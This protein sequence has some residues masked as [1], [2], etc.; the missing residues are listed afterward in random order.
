M[1]NASPP[2]ALH[3]GAAGDARLHELMAELEL[4]T[5]SLQG[6]ARAFWARRLGTCAAALAGQ[7]AEEAVMPVAQLEF[8]AVAAGADVEEGEVGA[9]EGEQDEAGAVEGEH[10]EAWYDDDGLWPG[11]QFRT[12]F[13][14]YHV[15]PTD[16]H[17]GH[18]ANGEHV[19]AQRDAR[20][21][22]G[23][24]QDSI[25]LGEHGTDIYCDHCDVGCAPNTCMAVV[26]LQALGVADTI[27]RHQRLVAKTESMGTPD[28][29]ARA[30]ARFECYKAVIAWQFSDPLGAGQRRRLPE[31]V[32]CKVRCLFRNP[33]C[34]PAACD[35][36][37]ECERR[38]HYTG[39]RTAE[40]SRTLREAES[41]V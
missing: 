15:A 39:F 1:P 37:A 4:L 33:V 30:S 26:M 13:D 29:E 12:I 32:T 3:E 10:D 2:T 9:E 23:R 34:T 31:C 16:A 40:E 25:G 21:G 41:L 35:F 38:G 22:A 19:G 6:D 11:V 17:D 8:G 5:E 20:L 27:A 14:Q 24:R 36:G 18:D 7:T 28:A